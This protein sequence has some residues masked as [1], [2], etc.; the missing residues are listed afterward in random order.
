LEVGVDVFLMGGK[1]ILSNIS[2]Y[3]EPLGA[4]VLVEMTMKRLLDHAFPELVIT[5]RFGDR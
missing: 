1:P 5:S 4:E 2:G 3:S